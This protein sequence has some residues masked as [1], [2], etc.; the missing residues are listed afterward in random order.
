MIYWTAISLGLVS[1]LHC[2]G[3][4]GPLVLVLP[5]QRDH[6]WQV[7]GS[8]LEYNLGRILTYG[9]MGLVF[10]LVGKG[11][12]M[13]EVQ[14][15]VSIVLG[16][17]LIIGAILG[18][19]LESGIYRWKPIAKVSG[20]V[21]QSFSQL[22]A[23]QQRLFAFGLLNGLLPCGMVY[24]ALAGAITMQTAVGGATFMLAFGLGT[25]PA[26]LAPFFVGQG[27][28]Q[29]LRRHLRTIQTVAMLAM[30]VVLITRGLQI[31][32]PAELSFWEMLKNPVMCH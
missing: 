16:G 10:G 9:I 20:F 6:T 7:L 11:L 32:F 21:K 22:L 2:L 12:L 8:G 14:Q 1:S 26:M 25:L 30:G 3:M 27:I 29:W 17:I 18:F 28:K 31:E 23:R 15:W 24:L 13:A 5:G 4:C 19:S